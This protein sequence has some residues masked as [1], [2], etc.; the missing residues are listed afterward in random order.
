MSVTFCLR[1]ADIDWEAQGD[2]SYLN[3]GQENAREILTLLGFQGDSE[4]MYGEVRGIVLR[5]ACEKA[6]ENLTQD[7]PHLGVVDKTPG[8]C[9]YYQL[10]RRPGYLKEK[11]NRLL[12]VAGHAGDL[13]FVTWS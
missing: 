12:Q 13:G 6:L 10:P 5:T 9:A 2:G 1:G 8:K 7:G 11:L 3:L 4:E